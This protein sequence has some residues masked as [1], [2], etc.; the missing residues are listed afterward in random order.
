LREGIIVAG[1]F[2]RHGVVAAADS[3][4]HRSRAASLFWHP[5]SIDQPPNNRMETNGGCSFH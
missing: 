3:E 4:Q 1:E 5:D 2:S